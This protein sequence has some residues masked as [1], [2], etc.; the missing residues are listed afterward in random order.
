MSDSSPEISVVIPVY[1]GESFIRDCLRTLERA[2]EPFRAEVICVDDSSTDS[3]VKIIAQDFPE[4]RLLR[5]SQN[6]GFAGTCNRGLREASGE[7]LFL[8]NQDTRVEPD[9]IQKLKNKLQADKQIA[10]IGPKF[11]GFDG[12]IQKNC[13]AFPTFTNL[14]YRFSGLAAL[15]SSSKRFAA[16]DMRWFGHETEMIVDQPMGAALLFRH[17]LLDR[18]GYLDESFPM[19]LNDVDLAK[20][21]V[22]AGY[23]NLYYPEAVVEHFVGGA[24]RPLKPRMV[25]ESHRS[26]HRYLKKWNPQGYKLPAL[27]IWRIVLEVTGLLRSLYWRLRN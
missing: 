7:L 15:F 6:I 26:L 8:V 11:V 10:F 12:K 1:N 5:N 14:F 24:T 4:V 22:E 9:S 2:L 17:D 18:I 19:Y 16:W 25:I 23:Y 20:R 3:S 27:W 21:A 13:A